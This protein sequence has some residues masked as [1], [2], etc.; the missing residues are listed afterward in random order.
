[1]RTVLYL[2]VYLCP[3][4][5]TCSSATGTSKLH[6]VI[7]VLDPSGIPVPGARQITVLSWSVLR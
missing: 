5:N 1:M 4:S 3:G 6:A 7:E 2:T